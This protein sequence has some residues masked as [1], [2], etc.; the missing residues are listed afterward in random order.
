MPFYNLDELR[1][2]AA[3]RWAEILISA[4]LPA[5]CLDGRN[6]PCP[7]CG[8]RDRFAAFPDLQQRGAVHC[9][10][11]FTRGCAIPPGDGMATLRWW[12]GCSFAE[13]LAFLAD[14]VGVAPERGDRSPSRSAGGS[15][16]SHFGGNGAATVAP[17]FPTDLSQDIVDAHT[18]FARE[19]YRRIDRETRRRLAEQLSVSA[20]ALRALRV[21]LTTDRQSST[22]P[23]RNET[24]TVIGVR[25][26]GLPWTDQRHAKWSRRGSQS[27]IFVA[28]RVTS[29]T[30]F[31]ADSTRLFITEGASDTA[32]AIG[33]G[34]WVIGRASCSA[35][36]FFVDRYIHRH[37][38]SQLTIIADNDD[39]G[40]NGAKRLA[41]SLCQ[42]LPKSLSEIDVIQPPAPANDFRAWVG[43]A[44]PPIDLEDAPKIA[45]FAPLKQTKFEFG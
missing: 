23:M 12:L 44:S 42:A 1:R 2:A 31:A 22:W 27:G 9:R 17:S 25:I 43:A 45:S 38:P 33:L 32:A 3:G 18:H 16:A 20:D 11:C 24:H 19:A 41:K 5:A 26:C 7:K 35:S 30:S 39:A 37:Q 13:S 8:G 36:T 28:R 40:R 14:A 15:R 34:L 6:R 10:H 29:D 4:G 21:G